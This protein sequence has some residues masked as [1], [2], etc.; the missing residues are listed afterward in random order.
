MKKL[1]SIILTLS[2][3]LSLSVP[4][5]AESN[6]NIA[7]EGGA[8]Y[9]GYQLLS[10][11]ASVK[12]PD[13]CGETTHTDNCYNYAY[14]VV[15]KYR[16]TLQNEVWGNKNWDEGTKPAAATDVTDQQIVE[17]LSDLSSDTDT[18]PGTLRA[19]AD[20]I[21]RAITAAGIT[22]EKTDLTG[23]DNLVDDGYWMIADV[24]NLNGQNA[25]N[26][27]VMVDTRVH[28][29]I[30][31][32]PKKAL[33][34]FEKK[35]K[36]INNSSD[37]NIVDN[38]WAD[39]ADHDMGDAVPFKLT[40]TLPANVGSYNSYKMVFHDTLDAGFALSADK[41]N[42]KVLM[43]STKAAADS[44][45]EL[46]DTTAVNVTAN[47]TPVI[48]G[49]KL[50]VTCEN[51]LAINGATAD[52]AFVVYYEAVLD[53][54]AVVGGA[55]NANT[56]YLEYSNDPYSDQTGKSTEDIV[57]VYTYKVVINKTDKDGKPLPGAGF[58]LYKKN[59]EGTY[60]IIGT[61][62]TGGTS[63][64]W[65]GLDDGDYKLEEST[66][67]AGYNKIADVAFTITAAHSDT[68][69]TSLD[70]GKLGTGDFSTGTITKAIE[71]HTGIVL[72]ETGAKGTMML[73][74]GSSALILLAGV[75]MVTRKKMSIYE[76]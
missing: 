41:M 33:P 8:T 43:Y 17:Y 1:I 56:A 35:V 36:D 40:G 76:D 63:F 31:I 72:P 57:K 52:T 34:E 66:V 29:N 30:T 6:I 42:Y 16:T 39:S 45:A 11:T 59:A 62:K 3:V 69:I 50:T 19:V 58:K 74:I 9:H 71:N 24:T 26:S 13:P 15:G 60:V 4:A 18:A 38:P 22:A 65:T 73:L 23:T 7:G 25:A 2:L 46:D 75:F 12:N 10:L 61:E 70:G 37:A 53:N 49:Q 14:S 5:F 27:L 32:A 64:E 51:V 20:R 21:Y 54:D 47:F 67:P 44:D 68:A 48:N 55:G 28:G